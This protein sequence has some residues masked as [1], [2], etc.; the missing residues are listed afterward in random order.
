MDF[1]FIFFLMQMLFDSFLA[2]FLL[3]IFNF[4][5]VDLWDMEKRG[6]EKDSILFCNIRVASERQ[7]FNLQDLEIDLSFCSGVKWKYDDL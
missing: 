3:L 1:N 5:V 2:L 7:C 4:F 6:E